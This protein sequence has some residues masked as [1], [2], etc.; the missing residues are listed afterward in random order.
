MI[1]AAASAIGKIYAK[2]G[3]QFA[4]AKISIGRDHLKKLVPPQRKSCFGQ[5]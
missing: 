4:S 1:G 3:L 5:V 2:L